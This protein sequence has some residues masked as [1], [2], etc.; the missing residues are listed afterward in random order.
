MIK[1]L[2]KWLLPYL[3]RRAERSGA[4]PHVFLAVC[5]HF[6]PLHDT[7]N[8]GAHRRIQIWSEEFP[9]LVSQFADSDGQPPKHTFFYP[10]EQYDPDLIG[11][12]SEL[13]HSTGSEVEVHLHHERDTPEGLVASLE[14]G[15]EDLA[16]HGLLSRDSQGRLRFG[17][18]HGNWALN[19][20][21][22]EGAGCGVSREIPILRKAGCYADFTMPSAPS[23]TQSKVVNTIGYLPD[24]E[25]R[26][27][28][29]KVESAKVGETTANRDRPDRLLMIQGP[30]ALN[31]GK[32]KWNVFPKIENGDLTGANPPTVERVRLGTDQ[33][34]SV[35]GK[36]DWVFV[37][38]H[39]HGGIERNFEMLL[40]E[41]MRE[42]HKQISVS[43]EFFLHYVTAREMANLVHAAEDGK[44]T[45]PGS[46]RDYLFRL[47]D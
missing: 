24:L 6:E 11:P 17:F 10:V 42:F 47:L 21:H 36:P 5:D 2:D 37:K 16:R 4:K 33:V 7:D 14:K 43:Q 23:P 8:A 9:K 27:A 1:A 22:P 45:D 13:C 25:G 31:W 29:D 3:R 20:S 28:L 39:T 30:L 41:P 35:A 34:I 40:G 18:I 26:L 44:T 15:K 19:H 12:L 46:H 38:L 32:R